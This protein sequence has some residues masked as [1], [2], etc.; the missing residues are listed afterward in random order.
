LKYIDIIVRI[1]GGLGISFVGITACLFLFSS[2]SNKTK[3]S[4]KAIRYWLGFL[5]VIT[6]TLGTAYL[7]LRCEAVISRLNTTY[8]YILV[9]IP[10][11]IAACWSLYVLVASKFSTKK[12][13]PESK[14]I[15]KA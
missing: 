5:L 6:G 3:F 13:K 1:I 9:R 14:I 10:V 12:I 7:A 4:I 15:Y 8:G 2:F 11:Y